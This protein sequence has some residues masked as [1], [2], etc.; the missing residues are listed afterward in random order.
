MG[1]VGLRGAGGWVG[2]WCDQRGMRGALEREG[3]E[4]SFILDLYAIWY[5]TR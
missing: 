1:S 3:D 4:D 5:V 2:G